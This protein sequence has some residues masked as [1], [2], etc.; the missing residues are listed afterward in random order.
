[1]NTIQSN[2]RVVLEYTLRDDKGEVLDSSDGDDGE[3][4]LYVHGYGM[5]VPGLEAALDGLEVG[6]SKEIRVTPEE[7]FGE[8]DEELVMEIEKS[9]FPDPANVTVGDEVVAESPDG[10]EVP[11]RVMEVKEESVVVDANHPL[12]GVTLCYSVKVKEVAAASEEEI[13][14]AAAGFDDAGYH[15]HECD[16]PTH[17]HS[18]DHADGHAHGH[19]HDHPPAGENLVQLGSKKPS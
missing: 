2:A 13:A 16:D 11:M 6:A 9:D 12:A 5:L 18:H 4:I 7:G 15:T 10:E 8:R 1:M 3:P 17:D 14:E 19:S